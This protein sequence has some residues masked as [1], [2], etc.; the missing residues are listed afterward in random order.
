MA[1][2]AWPII[3]VG[4]LALLFLVPRPTPLENTQGQ[5]IWAS[6]G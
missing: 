6:V 5:K 3:S 4:I 1:D 2:F